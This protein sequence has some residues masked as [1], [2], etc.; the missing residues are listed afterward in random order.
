MASRRAK[1]RDS[2]IRGWLAALIALAA[3]GAS[4]TSACAAPTPPRQTPPP[5]TEPA[6]QTRDADAAPQVDRARAE[7]LYAK[8]YEEAEAGKKDLAAGKAE[9]AKKKFGKALHKLYEATM[10][11]PGH[12]Q[13]WNMVGFCARKTGDLKRAFAAYEKCLAI[14][15]EYAEAHEYLGEAYLASGNIPKAKE[16][17]NWLRSRNSDEAGELAEKIDAATNRDPA[18]AKEPVVPGGDAAPAD[19]AADGSAA[20]ADS[21]EAK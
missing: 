13:A 15:P 21:A 12:Y 4:A 9:S 1:S 8:G 2:W 3:T 6:A 5:Q 11:D 7:K 16:Q 18:A 14:E 19:S 17:L 20:P 10:L